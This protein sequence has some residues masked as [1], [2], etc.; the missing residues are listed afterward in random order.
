MENN[1]DLGLRELSIE[2]ASSITGG[3]VTWK[4]IWSHAYS[5]NWGGAIGG[6]QEK[7]ENFF[8]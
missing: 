5:G 1:K 6:V 4:A 3:A 7:I 8:E 2:E